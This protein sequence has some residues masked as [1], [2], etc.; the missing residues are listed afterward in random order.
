VTPQPGAGRRELAVAVLCCVVGAAAVLT[1]AGRAWVTARAVQGPLQTPLV[2]RGGAAVPE[3]PALA[4][5]GLA[6]A[7]ALLA[8]RGVVRA[9]TGLVIAACGIGAAVA[10]ANGA[11]PGAGAL[12]DRAGAALGTGSAQ[13]QDV[14][15]NGWPMVAVAGALLFA[16]G[17]AL[18]MVRGRRWPGMSARYDAPHRGPATVAAGGQGGRSAPEPNGARPEDALEQWRALDRGEDPTI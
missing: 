6:G 3:A 10:A 2:V 14:A 4:V 13:V 18:A 11:R 1:A 17:G 16:C 15:T 5:V 7:L 12:E 9:A 8:T